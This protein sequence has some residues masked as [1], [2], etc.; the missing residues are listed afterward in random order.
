[1]GLFSRKASK[2]LTP[3]E[4]VRKISSLVNDRDF[5]KL[6]SKLRNKQGEIYKTELKRWSIEHEDP[7]V[8]KI[9]RAL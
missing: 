7:E 9:G 1:M 6:Q 8:N 4:A 2:V 5:S 3:E